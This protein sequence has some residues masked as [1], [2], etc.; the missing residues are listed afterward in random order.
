[1][2]RRSNP[3][4]AHRTIM[5]AEVLESRDVPS[6]AALPKVTA[7]VPMLQLAEERYAVAATQNGVS[8]VNVYN[9]KTNALLGIINP[10]ASK[11]T[12]NISIATGDVTGDGVEDIVVGS[13]Q[14][15][16]P[17]VKIYNGKTLAE[18]GSFSPFSATFRGGTTV[19]VGDVDGDGRKD[20][21]VGAGQGSIAHV[22]VFGGSALVDAQGAMAK[23]APPAIR[24]FVAFDTGY[25]GGVSVA[26]GDTDGDGRADIIV[27]K[28]RGDAMDV[29]VFSG[30]TGHTLAAFSA[31]DA[32]FKGGITVAAGDTNGDGRAEV[33]VGANVAP[34]NN[35]KVFRGSQMVAQFSA[36][37]GW[38]TRV[39]TTDIDGDGIVELVAVNGPG[40]PNR[41]NILSASTGAIRRSL[42][43][44][45]A[46]FHGGLGI[47]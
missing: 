24:N 31:Y 1:M 30:R 21:V 17:L 6:V 16:S 39:A 18:V 36:N 46:T 26:A 43:A 3:I 25:R 12:G 34:A 27:G 11:S 15:S 20:I 8:Q 47:G 7:A 14:G 23:V 13:G 35:V 32:S 9:A 22:K 19:A 40:A 10:F 33:V 42:P 44:M 38:S 4:P 45:P 29:A 37:T 41:V 28:N 5:R 2:D